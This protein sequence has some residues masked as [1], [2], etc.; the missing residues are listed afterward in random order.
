MTL[1]RQQSTPDMCIYVYTFLYRLPQPTPYILYSCMPTHKHPHML[2]A[3]ETLV[4][5]GLRKCLCA[6]HS[7]GETTVHTRYPV[8][9]SDYTYTHTGK[10][11]VRTY[12]YTFG[13]TT[14][15]TKCVYTCTHSKI[16]ET[17]V[18]TRYTV[19][20]YIYAYMYSYI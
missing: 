16:G 1:A 7:I 3:S 11:A 6:I 2:N 4:H 15:H 20:I 18:H 19:C 17:T 12:M 14:V 8:H 13:E 10:T 9:L 5:T